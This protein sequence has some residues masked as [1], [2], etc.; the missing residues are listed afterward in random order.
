MKSK[1]SNQSHFYENKKV[2]IFIGVYNGEKTIIKTLENLLNQTYK[3]EQIIISENHSTDKTL[4]IITRLDDRVKIISPPYHLSAE[5]HGNFCLDYISRELRQ[6]D[7]VALYHADDIYDIDIIRAQVNFLEENPQVPIVFTDSLIVN[8]NYETIGWSFSRKKSQ[9]YSI[10]NL[11][12]VLFG[13]V[14]STITLLCSSAMIKRSTLNTNK[15][16]RVQPN[17]FAKASDYGL[18]LEIMSDYKYAGLI[19]KPLVKYR[20]SLSSDSGKLINSI[21]ES[22]IFKIIRYYIGWDGVYKYSGWKWD[23]HIR[24]LILQDFIRRLK[25]ELEQKNSLNLLP[26]PVFTLGFILVSM[27]SLS[28][29]YYLSIFIIYKLMVLLPSNIAKKTMYIILN[30]QNFIILTRKFRAYLNINLRNL[31]AKSK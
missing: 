8:E 25:V 6:I 2:V 14:S 20:K 12:E 15:L 27:Q 26:K 3:I 16:Y 13:M 21:E 28:G 7:Y 9:I 17:I 24:R 23:A 1:E 5:D 10:Y 18:W 11:E 30:N 19:H 29:I 22:S 31:K 4:E